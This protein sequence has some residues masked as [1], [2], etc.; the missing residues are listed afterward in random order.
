MRLALLPA[1]LFLA[2]AGCG[3]PVDPDSGLPRSRPGERHARLETVW[4]AHH[5]SDPEWS[6]VIYRDGTRLPAD[7]PHVIWAARFAPATGW[8]GLPEFRP[9]DY[10]LV[11]FGRHA[12]DRR[13]TTFVAARRPQDGAPVTPPQAPGK[14]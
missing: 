4:V 3:Q 6:E 10:P 5:P 13:S 8:L 7:A 1:V 14:I 9:G 12:A 11:L 2:L